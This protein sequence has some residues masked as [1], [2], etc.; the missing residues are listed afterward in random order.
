MW[1]NFLSKQKINQKKDY[2]GYNSY[3]ASKPLEE[4]QIDLGIF[5]DSA[6]NNNGYKYLFVAIDIFTK[7]THAVPIKDKKP[8][9]VVRALNEVFDNI[10][11]PENIYHDNEG[12]FSSVEFIRLSNS[13]KVKQIITSSPPPFVEL[14][15]QTAKNMIHTRVEGLRVGKMGG[16]NTEC[17]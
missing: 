16:F 5:T 9:E 13:K 8:S 3:V 6:D 1:K 11:V 4:I 7:Y 15:I 17:Y 12:S 10:G 14:V 2:K